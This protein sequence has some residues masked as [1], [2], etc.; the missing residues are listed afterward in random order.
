MRNEIKLMTNEEKNQYGLIY[1]LTAI[2]KYSDSNK[3]VNELLELLKSTNR[4]NV[5]L[6][7]GW[8]RV[9]GNTRRKLTEFTKSLGFNINT[10]KYNPEEIENIALKTYKSYFG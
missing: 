10:L 3:T 1:L 7:L 8:F 4:Y 9:C 2:S 6:N 5:A